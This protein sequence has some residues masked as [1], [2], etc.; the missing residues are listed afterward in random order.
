MR[1]T[2]TADSAGSG[3]DVDLATEAW[4]A[5]GVLDNAAK[6]STKIAGA[7]SLSAAA[8]D[9]SP[10]VV[11]AARVVRP[12]RR[13]WET[14]GDA[15]TPPGVAEA[16]EAAPS[17]PES[18]SSSISTGTEASVPGVMPL[19]TTGV[20]GKEAVDA[21]DDARDAG[22]RGIG[23]NGGSDALGMDAKDNTS[24]SAETAIPEIGADEVG[25]EAA[26]SEEG[27]LCGG[28]L[29]VTATE[30]ACFTA[31]RAFRSTESRPSRCFF[32]G[33]GGAD[34]SLAD[35]FAVLLLLPLW[36][37]EGIIGPESSE[38]SES[39]ARDVE[40]PDL[41]AAPPSDPEEVGYNPLK[42]RKLLE[43]VEWPTAVRP[44]PPTR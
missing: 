23:E 29:L 7:A 24:L 32:L 8:I 26:G 21:V 38:L 13:G 11:G 3:V 44:I 12:S 2:T 6:P 36:S 16:S 30:A 20:L 28:P 31:F 18:P 10:A 17:V 5:V 22:V 14:T 15:N 40:D 4:V 33:G 39:T 42:T 37:A 1:A 34:R 9:R 43:E 35:D 41:A 19:E 27:T 25:S